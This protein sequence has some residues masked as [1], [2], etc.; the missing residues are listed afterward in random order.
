MKFCLALIFLFVSQIAYATCVDGKSDYHYSAKSGD[1]TFGFT[2][3]LLPIPVGKQFN[4]TFEVC[5]LN[6]KPLPS[7][8]KIDADMPA[9]KHGMNYKAKVSQTA[10]GYLAEG[11]MFHM[12]GK[13]RVTFELEQKDAATTPVRLSQEITIE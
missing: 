4:V 12:R 6:G 3:S 1:Y 13:W 2:P 11:L 9:H 7:G 8:V 10:K 5:S